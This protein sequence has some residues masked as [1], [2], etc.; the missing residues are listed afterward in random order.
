MS[1]SSKEFWRIV[2]NLSPTAQT[3]YP[4][5]KVNYQLV[6]DVQDKANAFNRRFTSVSTVSESVLNLPMPDFYRCTNC[7][8]PPLELHPLDVYHILRKLNPH[9]SKGF[10]N[11]PD[12]L[13]TMCSQS[14]ATP[15]SLLFNF[16]VASKQYPY[17]W[18]C[19]TVI[20]LFKSGSRQDVANYRPISLLPP[21]SKVFEKLVQMRLYNY[22]ESN[23]LLDPRNSGFRKKTFNHYIAFR[24]F[25]QFERSKGQ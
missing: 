9:K 1:T 3:T 18:K 10:N 22:L 2:R 6:F 23:H 16:I 20:P 19:A 15:F 5:L 21:L 12:C 25:L 17:A 24:D 8:M 7:S 13:L 11:L 4:S 14:L